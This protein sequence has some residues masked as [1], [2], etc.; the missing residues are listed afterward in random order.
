MCSVHYCTRGISCSLSVP[1]GVPAPDVNNGVSGQVLVTWSAPARPNGEI[2][3]YVIERAENRDEEFIQRQNHTPSMLNVFGDTLVEP[4]TEYR[5]R[6]VAVNSAGS[7]TGPA[8]S[9][10]TPEAG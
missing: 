8:T 7:G 4:F 5:Y 6:I 9:I 10:L 1:E 3:Y 2:L